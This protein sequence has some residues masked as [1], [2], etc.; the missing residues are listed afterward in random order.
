MQSITFQLRPKDHYIELN[1]LL[2]LQQVAQSGG[3]ANLMI[4]DGM[5]QVNGEVEHRKRNKIRAGDI[6][7]VEDI[8]I[9]VLAAE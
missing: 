6:V 9:T 1:K 7:S 2:K 8:E 3:H 5:V 4:E